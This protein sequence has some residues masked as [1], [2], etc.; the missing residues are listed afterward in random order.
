[1]PRS[2]ADL[3]ASR[4]IKVVVDLGMSNTWYAFAPSMLGQNTAVDFAARALILHH[5]PKSV[6]A[7]VPYEVPSYT[8]YRIALNHLRVSLDASDFSL[9]TTGLLG[10]YEML[11]KDHLA[12]LHTHAQ[13]VSAVIKA[14]LAEGRPASPVVRAALYSNTVMT[15]ARPL[16]MGVASPFDK[17]EWLELDPAAVQSLQT[18]IVKLSK[19]AHQI[20]LRIPRLIAI[21]RRLRQ[22]AAPEIDTITNARLIADK[23]FA[24]KDYSSEDELLRTVKL[25]PSTRPVGN[26]L[27]TDFFLFDSVPARDTMLMYWTARLIIVK[28]GLVL[29]DIQRRNDPLSDAQSSKIKLEHEQAGLLLCVLMCWN[30]GFGHVNVFNIL[31]SALMGRKDVRGHDAQSIRTWIM[32]QHEAELSGWGFK[33]GPEHADVDADVLAGGPLEGSHLQWFREI[34]LIPSAD[35]GGV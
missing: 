34:G 7:I 9:M 20:A 31:W 13:G 1:M 2:A 15:F 28:L 16:L 32:W 3:L 10:L 18:P 4:L 17:P 6:Q 19:I 27:D 22:S 30:N 26:P 5:E 8:A 12:A 14:H 23:I 21:T 29:C 33:Y 25:L 11:R 35:R 24:L